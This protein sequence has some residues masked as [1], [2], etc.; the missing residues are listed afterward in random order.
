VARLSNLPRANTQTTIIWVAL[1]LAVL[2]GGF[3]LAYYLLRKRQPQPAVS[4]GGPSLRKHRLLLEL[5][6][7]DDDF[8]AGKIDGESYRRLRAEKKSQLLSLIQE[9]KS[10][11]G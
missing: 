6:Q 10:G 5:S 3:G 7:L 8:E 9:E 2:I 11:R 1:I 4:E